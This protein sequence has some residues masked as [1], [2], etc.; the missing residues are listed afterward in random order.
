MIYA[1]VILQNIRPQAN[2]QYVLLRKTVGSEA[3]PGEGS[4]HFKIKDDIE[5]ARRKQPSLREDRRGRII[6]TSRK[7]TTL[8]TKDSALI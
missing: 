3:S 8:S 7:L 1:S 6:N 5:A 4:S 2:Y